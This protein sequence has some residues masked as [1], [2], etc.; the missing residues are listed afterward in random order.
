MNVPNITA[1]LYPV[2]LVLANLGTGVGLYET[3]ALGFSL[4]LWLSGVLVLLGIAF[5]VGHSLMGSL[6]EP[7]E[8]RRWLPF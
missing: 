7:I 8:D 2:G 6:L 4:V 5:S 1:P 3:G